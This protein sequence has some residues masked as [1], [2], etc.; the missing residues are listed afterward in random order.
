MSIYRGEVP[1]LTTLKKL[2]CLQHSFYLLLRYGNP[3]TKELRGTKRLVSVNICSVESYSAGIFV[4][5]VSPGI[6]V[7]KVKWMP[8]Y[9]RRDKIVI[10]GTI[11]V[12]LPFWEGKYQLLN[13]WNKIPLPAIFY[14]LNFQ[15]PH[16]NRSNNVSSHKYL[17]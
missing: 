12:Q 1:D 14:H 9:F 6:F 16:P 3:T 7:I 13:S 11:K 10:L 8:Y 17:F 5:K 15:L 4:S 2:V